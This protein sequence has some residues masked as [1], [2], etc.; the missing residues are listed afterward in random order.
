M[1]RD[2]IV[3]KDVGVSDGDAVGVD[4]GDA[5]GED[6]GRCVGDTV[7]V[8]EGLS[9]G[10][11]SQATGH[12]SLTNEELIVSPHHLSRRSLTKFSFAVIH[13]QFL[14]IRFPLYTNKPKKYVVESVHANVLDAIVDRTKMVALLKTFILRI[15]KMKLNVVGSSSNFDF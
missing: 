2:V 14:V 15:N 10:H 9:L 3:G 11:T 6:V 12:W 1:G 7:G 5:V 4:E 13:S 8:E